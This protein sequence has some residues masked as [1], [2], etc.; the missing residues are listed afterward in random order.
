MCQM[1][2]VYEKEGT[3]EKVMDNVTRLEVTDDGVRVE[4]FFEEPAL[5]PAAVVKRIDFLNNTVVLADR[6]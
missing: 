1:N 6:G 4:A 2:V 5:V 3:T